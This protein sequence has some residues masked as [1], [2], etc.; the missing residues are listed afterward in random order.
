MYFT[1]VN[2][3]FEYLYNNGDGLTIIN[4][5]GTTHGVLTTTN[6]PSFWGTK[7]YVTPPYLLNGGSKY[8]KCVTAGVSAIPIEPTLNLW[9]DEV[10]NGDFG[11]SGV[12]WVTTAQPTV[13]LGYGHLKSTDGSAQSI[14]QAIK[15]NPQ[16]K[17]FL[18]EFDIIENIAGSL[19]LAFSGSATSIGSISGV[20][21]KKVFLNSTNTYT[22]LGFIR[23]SGVT[24]IKIDNVVVKEVLPV[25]INSVFKFKVKPGIADIYISNKADKTGN[26]YVIRVQTT[27][28]SLHR[29]DSGTLTQLATQSLSFVDYS[30][31]QVNITSG[32]ITVDLNTTSN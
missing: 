5:I 10:L 21:H 14:S 17:T 13:N 23:Q 22:D 1:K 8:Y 6:L 25:L 20:G 4:Q 7:A 2:S 31:I 11:N 18:I 29:N 9:T 24:D 26:G 30:E 16:N 28:I 15:N 3:L 27:A 32:G 12:G 19:L